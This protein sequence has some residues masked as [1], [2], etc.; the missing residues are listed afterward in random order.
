MNVRFGTSL[1]AL[2]TA[3]L[4]PPKFG[5]AKQA[6]MPRLISDAEVIARQKQQQAEQVNAGLRKTSD[7][8]EFFLKF[9]EHRESAVSQNVAK[10][11]K[12]MSDTKEQHVLTT[13]GDAGQDEQKRISENLDVS[14]DELQTAGISAQGGQPLSDAEIAKLKQDY[15]REGQE[16]D[17]KP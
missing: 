17:K 15:D 6:D 2:S 1:S 12:I 8:D 3:A 7:I 10:M 13:N 5:E 11:A 16:P 4:K 14:L 9:T